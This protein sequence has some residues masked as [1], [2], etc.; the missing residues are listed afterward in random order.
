MNFKKIANKHTLYIVLGFIAVVGTT[1]YIFDYFRLFPLKENIQQLKIENKNLI[2][3]NKRLLSKQQE[4]KHT[5][6]KLQNE[7]IALTDENNEILKNMSHLQQNYDNANKTLTQLK[8][9]NNKQLDD[10]SNLEKKLSQY[11]KLKN[12]N[13]RVKIQKQDTTKKLYGIAKYRR[14]RKDKCRK[15][16]Y[17]FVFNASNKEEIKYKEC[18]K[19]VENDIQQ[20]K[21]KLH[22]AN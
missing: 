5:I 1:F 10:I 8:E 15:A 21:L 7:N 19:K 14:E 12:T 6:D 13:K 16:Y 3:E 20:L 11:K 22:L 2:S 18:L 17:A 4:Y 9:Q